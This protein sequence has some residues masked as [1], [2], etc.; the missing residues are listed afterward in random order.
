L[1]TVLHNRSQFPNLQRGANE[2]FS[3]GRPGQFLELRNGWFLRLLLTFR[4]EPSVSAGGALK[5][6]TLSSSIQYQN[7]DS[8]DE[9]SWVF[10]YEYSRF[11]RDH[12]APGH[13]HVRATPRGPECLV[14][15]LLM[16]DVHFPTGRVTLEGII[17]LLIDD[18]GVG[19]NEDE[20]VWR[21]LLHETEQVF[22]NIAR[23]PQAPPGR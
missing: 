22:I 9:Q 11:A 12:Y 6:K 2:T 19:A 15:N 21:P 10:R 17:R 3:L 4:V 1:A 20:D 8:E 5:L 7:V 14:G 23:Q 16:E 18:F 13:L